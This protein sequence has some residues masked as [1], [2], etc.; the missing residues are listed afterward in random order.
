MLKSPRDRKITKFIATRCHILRLK[1]TEFDID[2]R[3]TT[4]LKYSLTKQ[5][6]ED[7]PSGERTRSK[8][9]FKF[10]ERQRAKSH[11]QV[12]KTVTETI[13]IQPTYRN[14]HLLFWLPT[15]SGISY[16]TAQNFT[17]KP[18]APTQK[19]QFWVHLSIE[20]CPLSPIFVF[21]FLSPHVKYPIM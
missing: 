15:C 1:C 17:F 8:F 19:K 2:R 7:K 12:A 9:K 11:L 3:K 5:D 16:C 18:S 20:V 4:S 10:I 21:K 6:T 13:N 14:K